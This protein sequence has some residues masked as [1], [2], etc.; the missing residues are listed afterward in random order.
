MVKVLWLFSLIT[1]IGFGIYGWVLNI[2]A[3]INMEPFMFTGKSIVGII[4]VFMA[5][6][7]SI[8]GLFVW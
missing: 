2:I 5:P 1:L 8:M 6:I 3:L 4:G 7:G